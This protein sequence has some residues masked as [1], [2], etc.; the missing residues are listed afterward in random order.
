MAEENESALDQWRASLDAFVDIARAEVRDM[1]LALE[2][3]WRDIYAHRHNG[4][5][6]E[7][8]RQAPGG[9]A[10][11]INDHIERGAQKMPGRVA[12]LEAIVEEALTR[13]ARARGR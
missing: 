12:E 11:R 4:T 6:W 13:A 7:E 2:R 3:L 8:L 1:A 10:V 5:S 9:A